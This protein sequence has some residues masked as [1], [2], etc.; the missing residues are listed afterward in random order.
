MRATPPEKSWRERWVGWRNRRIASPDFQRWAAA[1]PLTRGIARKNAK[2]LFDVCAGFVYAQVLAAAADLNLFELLS[3]GARD[4]SDI[5]QQARLPE[6]SALTLLRAGSSLGLFEEIAPSRFALGQGGAALLGNPGVIA[7]IAH[8]KAL[9]RDL[10]DPVRLLRERPKDTALAQ[11]WRYPVAGDREALSSAEVSAY[12]ALMAASQSFIAE[13]VLGAFPFGRFKRLLDIGGGAGAFLTSAL[14]RHSRLEGIL[15]D[16]PAVAEIARE[17]FSSAGL[18]E[19]VRITGG[20]FYRTKLPEGADVAS[21]V[22]VIHDHDDE[23]ALT[24]LRAAY[25]ALPHNGMLVIAEP[26]AGT[27]GAE[28]MGD[29]YFGFYLLAMGSGRPRSL[30]ELSALI[31]TA[32]FRTAQIIRSKRPLL[33]SILA[34]KR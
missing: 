21:L 10:A 20:D 5:A 34:A 17:K 33:I 14:Q 1:F 30:E 16:L 27:R 15:F 11:F 12:S 3:D 24:I 4:A 23:A 13:D 2:A 9:Y 29:A 25:A 28:A 8:H 26:M 32:G 18:S 6:A 19:R 31:Q 7:M 22:R